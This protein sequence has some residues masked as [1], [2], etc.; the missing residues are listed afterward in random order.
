MKIVVLDGY[1]ANPGDLSWSALE[2]LGQ[3][4]VYPRST[5]QKALQRMDGA[6]AVLS[7]K[8]VIDDAMME[9]C[10]DLRY[11]GLLATGYNIIDIAAAKRRG[12]TVT[13]IPAYSTQS[14]A[15]LTF[16]LLLEICHHVGAHSS[17][18]KDEGWESRPD[19]TSWD[20]PLVELA[21]K[22]M[23]L[24]GFGE[25]GQSVARIAQAFGMNVIIHTRTE[26]PE[27]LL[28]GMQYVSLDTLYERS[29]IIS[30]HCPLFDST[31]G[32]I[33]RES[34]AKMKTGV[35]LINTARGGITAEQDV[36]DALDAGKIAWMGVDVYTQEPPPAGHPLIC[37]PRC[38]A[39]PHF[40]WAPY[41]ARVRLLQIASDNLKAFAAGDPI[42]VV[43]S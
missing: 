43:N 42:H 23:G 18:L 15:Q 1:T 30:L 40:G 31:R 8:V 22:T 21:G 33:C 4:E 24:I 25:I 26:R 27:A 35:I 38:I 9:K 11:I 7:N 34:I 17:K 28:P 36:A 5:P 39:T 3:V 20:Y 6:W 37:H 29:D 10:P 32:L 14:V 13:N 19:F 16:A 41:E 12:I 2:A